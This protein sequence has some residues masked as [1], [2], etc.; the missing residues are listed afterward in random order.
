ME[1]VFC[2]NR[3]LRGEEGDKREWMEEGKVGSV[4]GWKGC[5]CLNRRLRRLRRL[6][7]E[8]GDKKEW[9]EEGK[10]GRDVFV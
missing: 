4:E 1:E 9:M 8:E 6:R 7:R 10:D 3:G 5:L 2:L